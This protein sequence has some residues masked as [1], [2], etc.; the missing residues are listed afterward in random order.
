MN[1]R[2]AQPRRRFESRVPVVGRDLRRPSPDLNLAFDPH[3]GLLKKSGR[4]AVHDRVAMCLLR[5]DLESALPA[6]REERIARNR[7]RLKLAVA[8]LVLWWVTGRWL[9]HG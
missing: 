8:M 6:R 1:P 5:K 2:S 7:R 4:Q 9:I 3:T